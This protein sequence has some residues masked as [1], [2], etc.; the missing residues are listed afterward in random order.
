[1]QNHGRSGLGEFGASNGAL[2]E[3]N[4]FRKAILKDRRTYS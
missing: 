1:M 2:V 4:N 3:L